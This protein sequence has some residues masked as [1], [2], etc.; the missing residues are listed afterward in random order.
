MSGRS[1]K[2]KS[3]QLCPGVQADLLADLQ[4]QGKRHLHNG[5][6]GIARHVA[7]RDA[8]ALCGGE[9]DDVVARCEDTHELQVRAGG[10]NFVRQADLIDEND[11]RIADAGGHVLRR[12]AVIDRQLTEG[13]KFIPAQVAGIGGIGIENDDLHGSHPPVLARGMTADKRIP[14]NGRD[15][16][17]DLQNIAHQRIHRRD[18]DNAA[19]MMI[20]RGRM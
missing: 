5:A 19:P 4:Q 7:H 11:L 16:E 14:C 18:E 9:V 13:G 1:Q 15:R 2:Q 8:A 17:N 3:G 10:K 6:R 12:G 20:R